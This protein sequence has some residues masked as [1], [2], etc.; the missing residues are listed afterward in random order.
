MT[1]QDQPNEHRNKASGTNGFGKMRN[2]LATRVKLSPP[3]Q[4]RANAEGLF[5]GTHGT[6]SVNV[7]IGN[8]IATHRAAIA[9]A[10]YVL[11][12]DREIANELNAHFECEDEMKRHQ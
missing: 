4:T 8:V 7:C 3:I 6:V 2:D 9:A 11:E 1:C 5:G 10:H 12:R